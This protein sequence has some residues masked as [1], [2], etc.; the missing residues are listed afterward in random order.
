MVSSRPPSGSARP[1]SS[2]RSGGSWR[3]V[4]AGSR[5]SVGADEPS[6][7]SWRP[8]TTV[9]AGRTVEQPARRDGVAWR[10]A[11]PVTQGQLQGALSGCLALRAPL[12]RRQAAPRR[13]VGLLAA[14]GVGARQ[15]LGEPGFVASS[16]HTEC[17]GGPVRTHRNTQQPVASPQVVAEIS[18]NHPSQHHVQQEVQVRPAAHDVGNVLSRNR[19][20]GR[21]IGQWGH[22]AQLL[23]DR[24]DPTVL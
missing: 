3:P 23:V 9:V 8:R 14:A 1:V 16:V 22:E 5:R 7:P 20:L 17:T 6:I 18:P 12:D 21:P 10:L 24:V 13:W 19:R 15:W 4:P 2:C 11:G